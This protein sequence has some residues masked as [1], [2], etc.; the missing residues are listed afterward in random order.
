MDNSTKCF[1]DLTIA[2][3]VDYFLQNLRLALLPTSLN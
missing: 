2:V 1:G 3:L